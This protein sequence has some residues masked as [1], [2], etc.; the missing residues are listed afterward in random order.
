VCN[1]HLIPLLMLPLI[2]GVLSGLA[3]A[4]ALLHDPTIRPHSAKQ[5][6]ST[7]SEVESGRI[8]AIVV[9]DEQTYVVVSGH[10]YKV[11]DQ[12][13]HWQVTAIEPTRIEL[14]TPSASKGNK[15]NQ[16]GLKRKWLA[17]FSSVN[18]KEKDS[19]QEGI[20]VESNK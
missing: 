11:G 7:G 5:G 2:V 6:V 12:L 18:I 16:P 13:D 10:P 1:R 20:V 9:N 14:S 3:R 17:I 19:A 4:E 15:K 8:E